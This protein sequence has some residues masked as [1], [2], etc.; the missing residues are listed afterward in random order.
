MSEI[1]NNTV[2]ISGTNRVIT[3]GITTK[4]I[5]DSDWTQ[6]IVPIMDPLWSTDKDRLQTFKF[7]DDGTTQSY[8]CN[9]TKYV[10]NHTTGEYFWKDY[11][12]DEPNLSTAT[13]FVVKI[14]EA[15]DAVLSVEIDDIDRKFKRVMRDETGLSLSRIKGWRDFFLTTS[16]WTML[17][18]APVTA[19]E[20]L[21]WKDY[22]SRIRALPDAFESGIKVLAKIDLPIDPLVYKKHYQPHN[23]GVAYLASDEQFIQFPPDSDK[24]AAAGYQNQLDLIMHEYVMLAL[25]FSRPAPLYNVPSS[26]HLTDPVEVLIAQIEEDQKKLD[27]AKAAAG[28]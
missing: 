20:K 3:R 26:S 19:D 12:F 21:L 2:I 27:E 16:D 7:W 24:T 28:M 5:S 9:K 23:A 1:N 25:R 17:E 11:I 4:T 15:F 10:R 14:R 6:Y 13:D 18:D 8:T 22:R